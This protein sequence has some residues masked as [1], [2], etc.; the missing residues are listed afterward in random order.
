MG[1]RSNT[2][3]KK[4]IEQNQQRQ[5]TSKKGILHNKAANNIV[6]LKKIEKN[7]KGKNKYITD[8][9]LANLKNFNYP[10]N[11]SLRNNSINKN[12]K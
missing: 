11:R 12:K 7:L 8:S 4:E 6:E 1:S 3:I 10:K 2:P 9:G 5:T